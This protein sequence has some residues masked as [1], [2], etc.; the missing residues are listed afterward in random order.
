MFEIELSYMG[1]TN[2]N[3]D[4][5]CEKAFCHIGKNSETDLVCKKIHDC[6]HATIFGI[7]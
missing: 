3:S 4:I 1:E 7:Y 6:I 2:G 5:V